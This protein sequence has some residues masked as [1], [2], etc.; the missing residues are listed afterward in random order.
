MIVRKSIKQLYEDF[1]EAIDNGD[2]TKAEYVE[3]AIR[4][5]LMAYKE[6]MAQLNPEGYYD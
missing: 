4:E 2:Y 5:K 6:H 3:D 1:Y